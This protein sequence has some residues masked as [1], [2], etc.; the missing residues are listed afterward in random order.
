LVF[1]SGFVDVLFFFAACVDFVAITISY[2][3]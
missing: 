2:L 1:V 3:F